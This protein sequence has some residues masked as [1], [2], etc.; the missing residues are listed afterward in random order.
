MSIL[1][2][3]ATKVFNTFEGGAIICQDERTK[4]RIDYLKNFG[5]ANETTVIATGINGKMSEF[6]AALGLL[7]LK[8]IDGAIERR[9]EIDRYYRAQ[10]KS[11]PGLVPMTPESDQLN[12]SYF[13]VMVMPEF[14]LSRDQLY[15]YLKRHQIHGRRY[16]Y[17]LISDFPM[18][19]SLPSA[20]PNNLPAARSLA[21]RVICLP[22]YPDLN[23]GQ[24]KGVM[25]VLTDSAKTSAIHPPS[26]ASIG[27]VL[28]A[29]N[30]HDFSDNLFALETVPSQFSS[31]LGRVPRALL[32]G[33]DYESD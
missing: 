27:E 3:H 25:K 12:Q 31:P 6:N 32:P 4:Q 33:G 17:P 13:P 16:F 8:H 24:M 14:P 22:I 7:Q 23:D 11:I 30:L 2:F 18:Y 10:L 1:S 20:Q 21:D 29:N 19:R 26:S 9:R 15:E 5:F 28:Q